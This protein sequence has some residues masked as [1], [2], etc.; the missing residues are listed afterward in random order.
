MKVRARE[1]IQHKALRAFNCY[2]ASTSCIRAVTLK[3]CCTARTSESLRFSAGTQLSADC[4]S[5][6]PKPAPVLR[7]DLPMLESKSMYF[8]MFQRMSE[9]EL[10]L[11]LLRL[12]TFRL[13]RGGGVG[14]AGAGLLSF[15]FTMLLRGDCKYCCKLIARS[16]GARGAGTRGAGG[17]AAAAASCSE[18][19][20]LV[21]TV[22]S[23]LRCCCR[24]LLRFC[25]CC[26]CSR[27]ISVTVCAL[28]SALI[29][30]LSS[31]SPQFTTMDQTG[32]DVCGGVR[33]CC[34]LLLIFLSF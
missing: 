9:P 26:C 13:L 31:P 25:C 17:A 8:C 6:S 33:L 16:V 19:S 3:H 5:S 34:R 29:N 15:F 22:E 7:A 14:S 28:I 24:S 12:C 32:S 11:P 4:S 1:P 21:R 20:A 30:L 2:P 23:A 10:L 27:C 18:S